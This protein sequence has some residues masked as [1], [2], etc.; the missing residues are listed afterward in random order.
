MGKR[1][2]MYVGVTCVNGNCPV[3]LADEY[4]ERGMDVVSKCDDCFYY[5]GCDDCALYGTEYCEKGI[6]DGSR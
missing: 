3:A 4:E 5:K 2:E 6:E 1:C